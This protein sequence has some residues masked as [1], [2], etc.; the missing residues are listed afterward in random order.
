MKFRSLVP[1]IAFFGSV[2]A[3]FANTEPASKSWRACGSRIV[4]TSANNADI[5]TAV[6]ATHSK[7]GGHAK[8]NYRVEDPSFKQDLVH[9]RT[10]DEHVIRQKTTFRDKSGTPVQI[11]T[12][13]RSEGDTMVFFDG[14]E[15]NV[16]TVRDEFV[17]ALELQG[18]RKTQ[19]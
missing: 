19:N 5:I 13:H 11:E 12:I 7:L 4:I 10:D 18:V 6:R 3:L 14:G 16:E 1:A 17:A 2:I 15:T 8:D 9:G